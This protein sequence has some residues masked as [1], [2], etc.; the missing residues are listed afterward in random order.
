[1]PQS[2][3]KG[4]SR[5]QAAIGRQI[6]L[7][8]GQAGHWARNCPQ[9]AGD[10]K[11]RKTEDASD[12]VMMVAGTEV[13]SLDKDDLEEDEP[14]RTAVQDGGA[15]S[16]LGS[17]Y[18]VRRYLMFLLKQGYDVSTIEAFHCDKGFRY[19][20]S[21]VESTQKC[22]LLPVVLGGKKLKVLTYVIQ[23]TAPLL[24]GRPV[25]EQ[26][27]VSVD[28][29]TRRMRWPGCSWHDIP[30]G[31]K[32]E[33]LLNLVEDDVGVLLDDKDYERILVPAD[34]DNHIDFD[35]PIPLTEVVN[36]INGMVHQVQEE[37]LREP[38]RPDGQVVTG[39]DAEELSMD[40]TV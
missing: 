6:C 33:H 22:I 1:M 30:L 5:G 38:Q 10:S 2:P 8:C 24:F 9:A 26:L 20:N 32:G 3:A 23:G 19:G 15:S 37:E 7:R 13:F 12:E 34:Y 39:P 29:G 36:R 14:S 17:S 27:E 25:L 40:V 28:Y 31:P 16:V 11:K 18:S 21:S 35:N 4:K